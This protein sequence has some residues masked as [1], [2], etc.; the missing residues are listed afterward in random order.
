[1]KFKQYQKY[2]ESNIDWIGKIPENW[3]IKKNK[4]IFYEINKPSILGNETLLSVSDKYGIKPRSE[5]RVNLRSQGKVDV[6]KVA[7]YFGGGGHKAAAGATVKGK[8]EQVR[9]KVLAKIIKIVTINI[10][11]LIP[12][13]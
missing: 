5:I 13:I 4:H 12:T 1:M 11:K 9:K 7:Q 2:K 10:T 8:I 6:N 3:N